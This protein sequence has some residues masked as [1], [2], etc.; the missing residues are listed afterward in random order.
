[1]ATCFGPP[2]S[3]ATGSLT[4]RI[5]GQPAARQGDTTA[6]AGVITTGFPQVLIGG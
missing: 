4:V 2:D 5:G 3:I 6:H 1:M